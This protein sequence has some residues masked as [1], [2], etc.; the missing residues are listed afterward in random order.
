MVRESPQTERILLLMDLLMAEPGRGRTLAE[1]A[2]HLG[3][4]KATCYPMVIA[5]T[6]A[7]WLVRH[8]RHKTYQLGPA[9]IPVGQAAAGAIDV[10]DHARDAMH[11]LAD[12]ADVVC[13]GF[14]PSAADLV[15]AEIIQPASGR[16]GSLGLRLGDRVDFAPPLGAVAA[17]W[18][19][20]YQLG[21]WHAR[22]ER[23][24]GIAAGILEGAYSSALQLIRERGYAVEHLS[25]DGTGVAEV[26]QQQRGQHALSLQSLAAGPTLRELTGSPH[27]DSLLRDIHPE[28]SYRVVA[29][30][31]AVFNAE[32]AAALVLSLVDA[33]EPLAGD[34]VMELGEQI[35]DAAA[36]ITAR[37]GGVPP[38]E[39]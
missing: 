36:D 14:V 7:G 39:R 13:L 25:R 5:L 1:I 37:I 33:P 26:V 19:P 24:L 9:L 16:R 15:V 31:A 10:V 2:R 27:A 30:S 6:R 4:A 32:S 8:P 29:I 3:T 17:A 20:D 22:G 28:L 35:R 11:A 21:Q 23:D 34:R 38:S 12:A 18:L